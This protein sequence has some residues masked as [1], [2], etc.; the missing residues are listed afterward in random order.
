M[1]TKIVIDRVRLDKD[2]PAIA[3]MDEL[4]HNFYDEVTLHDFEGAV[5]ARITGT[6]M[7]HERV[8]GARVWVETAGQVKAKLR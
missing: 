4:G 5:V 8:G 6:A 3:V 1:S 2:E 7:G